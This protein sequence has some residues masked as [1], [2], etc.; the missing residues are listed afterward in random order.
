MEKEEKTNGM[1]CHLLSLVGFLGIPFGNIIGPLVMWLIKKDESEFVD[2]CGKESVNFQ[3][4][5][6]I[7]LLI[8]ALLTL[9][10]IGIVGIIAIIILHIVCV[11]K[12]STAANEG[13]IYV[14]PY[15]IRFIK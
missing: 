2:A 8:S 5:L 11:I 4:S 6:T 7:Y 1:L 13:E 15:T 3:I 9:I 10:V 14:Y 12:A